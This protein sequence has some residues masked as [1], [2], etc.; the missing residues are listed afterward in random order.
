[1]SGGISATTVAL[2]AGAGI[3]ASMMLTPK[4]SVKST[5]VATVETPQTSKTP[6]EAARR[7]TQTDQNTA[8]AAAGGPNNTLLTSGS[9]IDTSTLNLGKSTLLGQ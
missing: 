5:D 1:M 2:A 9:G 8:A 3:A 4:S 6:D 7:K